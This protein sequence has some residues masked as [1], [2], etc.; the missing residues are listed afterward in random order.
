MGWGDDHVNHVHTRA[1]SRYGARRLRSKGYGLASSLVLAS[2]IGKKYMA[3]LRLRVR[4]IAREQPGQYRK[5]N[6]LAGAESAVRS[7]TCASLAPRHWNQVKKY[8][9]VLCGLG[10]RR[11]A[12][13]QPG[14]CVVPNDIAGIKRG[15]RSPAL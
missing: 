6:A 14:Q 3:V 10:V 15:M 1:P 5:G 7:T 2:R 9:P 13:E 4:R 11:I 12:S 8:V